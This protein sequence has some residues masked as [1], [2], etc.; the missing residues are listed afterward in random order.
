M[1]FVYFP[2]QWTI[3]LHL[4]CPLCSSSQTI[5]HLHLQHPEDGCTDEI[6]DIT[7][8]V[9]HGRYIT[10]FHVVNNDLKCLPIKK[11][12]IYKNYVLIQVSGNVVMVYIDHEDRTNAVD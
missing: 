8:L 2:S 12:E 7:F 3:L 10:P 11:F 5:L 1:D 6:R 9:H 4:D